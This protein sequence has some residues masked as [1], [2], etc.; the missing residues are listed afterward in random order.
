VTTNSALVTDTFSSLRDISVAV[1]TI[2]ALLVATIGNAVANS[3]RAVE[4]FKAGDYMEAERQAKAAIAAGEGRG[5]E[6]LAGLMMARNDREPDV[7]GAIAVLREAGR[8]GWLRANVVLATLLR[9]LKRSSGVLGEDESFLLLRDAAE[10]GFPP[11]E[12]FVAREYELLFLAYKRAED[13]LAALRWFHVAAKSKTSVDMEGERITGQQIYCDVA[14][15]IERRL[16]S[17]RDSLAWYRYC[18]NVGC[19]AGMQKLANI[20]EVGSHGEKRDAT[21]AQQ[22]REAAKTAKPDG[23]SLE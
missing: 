1:L 2:G 22:W 3:D 9:T 15:R 16:Q 17:P 5:Y 20:Y 8:A 4:A 12:Y 6:I 10:R 19:G 14:W 23:C 13:R 21:V 11:A 18:A 7:D